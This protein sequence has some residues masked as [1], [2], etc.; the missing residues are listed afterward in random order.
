MSLRELPSDDHSPCS[1][2][3]VPLAAPV[4]FALCGGGGGGGGTYSAS[5]T[6]S[7]SRSFSAAA[8]LGSSRSLPARTAAAKTP[9]GR[10]PCFGARKDAWRRDGGRRQRDSALALISGTMSDVRCQVRS[11]GRNQRTIPYYSG[12]VS[13]NQTRQNS[14]LP[15]QPAAG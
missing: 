5:C 4:A 11:A 3:L 2:A 15:L 13:F 14:A 10:S 1:A 6:C 9:S 12:A 8:C 7:A